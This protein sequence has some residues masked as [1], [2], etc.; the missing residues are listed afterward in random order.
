M[1]HNVR[2]WI[3]TVV[4]LVSAHVALADDPCASKIADWTCFSAI[5]IQPNASAATF[6]MTIFSNQE[7]LAEIEQGGVTKKYLALPS[8]IALY[9][10]LSS[11]ESATGRNNPFML[12]ELGIALP[13]TALRTAFPLGPSSVPEGESTQDVHWPN[14]HAMLTTNRQRRETINYRLES[15]SIHV[16]GVWGRSVQNPLPGSYSLVGWTSADKATFATLEQARAAGSPN[17]STENV[18]R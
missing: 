8:G 9:I 14:N 18:T 13:V 12:M 16:K 6:R 15:T 2:S 7:L 4:L 10:G 3:L 17:K 5:A 1:P 11:E